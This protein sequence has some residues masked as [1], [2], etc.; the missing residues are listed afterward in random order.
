MSTGEALVHEGVHQPRRTRL[1]PPPPR[2]L[3]GQKL[4]AIRI[5]TGKTR[6]DVARATGVTEE[7]IAALENGEQRANSL[8][9]NSI[10]NI[11]SFL[12]YRA[13]FCQKNPCTNKTMFAQLCARSMLPALVKREH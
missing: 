7:Q 1:S 12:G 4:E 9:M 8:T 6:R 2:M 13:V 3:F 5:S 11:A 10:I